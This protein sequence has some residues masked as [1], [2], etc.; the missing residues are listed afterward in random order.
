VRLGIYIPPELRKRVRLAAA[1]RGETLSA[2][3]VRAIER[4]LERER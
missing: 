4:E 1:E 2:L 3:V